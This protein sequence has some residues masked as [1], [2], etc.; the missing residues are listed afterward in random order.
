MSFFGY[1]WIAWN[2]IMN[3]GNDAMPAM[4]MFKEVTHLPC[5][6]CGTTRSL[7]LLSKGELLNAL[8]TNPF[9]FV[10]AFLM[11]VIPVWIIV[12]ISL[13]KESFYRYYLLTENLLT[14]KPWI[15]I[16]AVTV[17]LLNWI[18]NITKGI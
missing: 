14:R 8:M 15:Y 3:P 4:C 2:I 13:R 18:W 11:I 17:I 10:I 6:S 1:A 12:D 5:P 16:P 9:G 7:I